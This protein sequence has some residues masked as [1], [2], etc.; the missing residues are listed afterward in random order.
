MYMPTVVFGLILLFTVIAGAG[1]A[2]PANAPG[3]EQATKPQA[4]LD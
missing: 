1:S 3:A 4:V 2:I